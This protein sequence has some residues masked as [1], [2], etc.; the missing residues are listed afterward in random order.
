MLNIRRE[1]MKCKKYNYFVN[2]SEEKLTITKTAIKRSKVGH[3]ANER[4]YY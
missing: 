4:F 1:Q 3:I 2:T